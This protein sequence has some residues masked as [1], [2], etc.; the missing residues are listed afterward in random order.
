MLS[1]ES[2]LQAFFL[3]S[4]TDMSKAWFLLTSTPSSTVKN[5]YEGIFFS[6]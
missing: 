3:I 5:S 2:L 1:I 4:T 6:Y